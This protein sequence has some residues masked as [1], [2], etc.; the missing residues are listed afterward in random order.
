MGTAALVMGILQFVCLG[1]IASILAIVFGAIGR[2][3]AK[4]GLATNGGVATAGFWLGIV[5]IIL[6]VIGGIIFA[7]I[8]VFGVNAASEALDPANNRNTGLS[9][10]YYSMEPNTWIYIGDRCSYGGT[11]TNSDGQVASSSVT[12]VGEGGLQC[13][14]REGDYG[15]RPGTV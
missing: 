12:V 5:G 15:S 7:A 8:V 10:G 11:P 6:S 9:D 4:Q 14:S 2:K 13:P 3:K 1:P